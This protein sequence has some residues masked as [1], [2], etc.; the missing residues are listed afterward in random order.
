MKG[1]QIKCDEVAASGAARCS[2]FVTFDLIAL[3]AK[4]YLRP[5]HLAQVAR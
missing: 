3:A 2:H 5:A 4:A 1:D